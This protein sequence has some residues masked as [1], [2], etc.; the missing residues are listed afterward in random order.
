MVNDYD[1]ASINPVRFMFQPSGQPIFVV[2]NCVTNSPTHQ[3]WEVLVNYQGYAQTDFNSKLAEFRAVIDTVQPAAVVP[4]LP[5]AP[6][7]S[8]ARRIGADFEF[9]LTAPTNATY[10]IEASAN[11]TAWN[12]LD[13]LPFT[14]APILFRE[15]NVP[16]GPRFYRA[17]AP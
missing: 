14:G 12:T 11:L 16:A 13:T 9:T 6:Q 4:P 5:S 1:G 10:R 2:L 8:N 3:P 15:T 17:V 7:L